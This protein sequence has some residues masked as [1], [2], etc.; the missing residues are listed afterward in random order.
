MNK[1]KMHELLSEVCWSRNQMKA[2]LLEDQYMGGERTV[3]CVLRSRTN[4][5]QKKVKS[6]YHVIIKLDETITFQRYINLQSIINRRVSV[7]LWNTKPSNDLSSLESREEGKPVPTN[8]DLPGFLWSLTHHTGRLNFSDN[9]F[10]YFLFT[11][12][13]ESQT[14]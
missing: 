8:N 1:K 2:R 7:I 3:Q 11:P 10:Y 9:M 12:L 6:V 5:K 4:C 14:L 13:L